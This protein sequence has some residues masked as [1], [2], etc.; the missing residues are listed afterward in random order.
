MAM[1]IRVVLDPIA[2][3]GHGVCAELYPEGI[4][5]DDW[6]YPILRQGDVPSHLERHARRAASACLS[7]AL[8]IRRSPRT[9]PVGATGNVRS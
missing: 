4:A 9:G 6:G 1:S 2:C 8:K 3:D 5:L 7:L